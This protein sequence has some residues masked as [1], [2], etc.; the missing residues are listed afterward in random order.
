[1]ANLTTKE[2]DL[3]KAQLGEEQN[4]IAKYKMYAATT[5]DPT[6][7]EELNTIASKHQNHFDRLASLLA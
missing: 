5:C 4:L 6:L 3:V 1:M 2:L 7:K